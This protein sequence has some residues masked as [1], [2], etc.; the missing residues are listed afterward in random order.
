MFPLHQIV[1]K[2]P[3]ECLRYRINLY[4]AVWNDGLHDE[5]HDDQDGWSVSTPPSNV[6]RSGYQSYPFNSTSLVNMGDQILFT[7]STSAPLRIDTPEEASLFV[8]YGLV[9]P[10]QGEF[11]VELILPDGSSE[12]DSDFH[13][14]NLTRSYTANR[15][16]E[17]MDELLAKVWLDP[18]VRYDAVEIR[19]TEEGRNMTVQAVAWAESMRDGSTDNWWSEANDRILGNDGRLSGGQIAGIVVC[20]H[21]A[22]YAPH[23]YLRVES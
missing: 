15:Q 10:D 12:L 1:D 2:H 7:Q 22:Q 20:S 21:I 6:S 4:A 3:A 19:S 23:L 14:H 5:W 18:R 11:E 8:L 16:V 13:P 17:S 9:G